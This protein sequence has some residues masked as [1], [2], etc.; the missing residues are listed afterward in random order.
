MMQVLHNRLI[1]GEEE[2]KQE[3][4]MSVTVNQNCSGFGR[5]WWCFQQGECCNWT[6]L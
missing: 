2:S 5:I 1:K 4:G 3:S 6:A